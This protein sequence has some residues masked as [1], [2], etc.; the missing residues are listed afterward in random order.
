MVA[1]LRYINAIIYPQVKR[2]R[3]V[4]KMIANVKQL[5]ANVKKQEQG[6]VDTDGS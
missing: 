6:E 2:A 1:S 3:K 4:N 5:A